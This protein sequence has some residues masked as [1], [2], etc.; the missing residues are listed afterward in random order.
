M[1]QLCVNDTTRKILLLKG[2]FLVSY[3]HLNKGVELSQQFDAGAVVVA[4][5]HSQ[6]YAAVDSAVCPQQL[7]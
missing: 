7:Q 6:V 3:G 2:L 4:Q 5:Q 1:L